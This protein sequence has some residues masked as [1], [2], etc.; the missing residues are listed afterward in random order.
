VRF[1]NPDIGDV[2]EEIF[3][4]IILSVGISPGKESNQISQIFGLSFS[5][6]GFL[7]EPPY[8][9]GI[10]LAG[11]CKGPKDIERSIIDAKSTAFKVQNFLRGLN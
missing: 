3:D 5:E 10:F 8:E 4:M 2:V 9:K 11:A 7:K 6:D 1:I